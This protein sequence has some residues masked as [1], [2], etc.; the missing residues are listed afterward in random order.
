MAGDAADATTILPSP[1]PSPSSAAGV[2]RP[3]P[4]SV[5]LLE[6]APD[7]V[8]E[9][10][11]ETVGPRN[12]VRVFLAAIFSGY[13]LLVALM[14]AIGLVLTE[15]ILPIGNLEREDNDINRWL[16]DNRSPGLED[17]S[18]VG[19]TLAGGHVIPVVVGGLLIAFLVMRRWLLA[20]FT[21]FAIS[22]ESGS[23]RA[24]TLVVERDRP[25]VERLESLPVEA[26]FP[27]GH[28]AAS[29]ALFGGLLLLLASRV[30]RGWFW[31]LTWVL[32]IAIPLFVAWARLY[33][34]MHHVT[35]VVAGLLMGALALVV[36]VFA[37]RAATAAAAR[38]DTA[39]GSRT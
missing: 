30:Q 2:D 22:V 25:P 4:R 17:A 29:V 14:I 3:E 35:D 26:S 32:V 28:T 21:L 9:R 16:A 12:P 18:W 31:A 6:P 1:S 36:T 38:R 5:A 37:A 27:S 7:G 34:G 24:T 13:A 19:S 23:Y 10:F 11:A 15:L 20:A 33:R 39:E 8:A